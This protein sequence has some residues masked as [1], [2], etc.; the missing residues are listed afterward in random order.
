MFLE[1]TKRD[2][3]FGGKYIIMF[4]KIYT[5]LLLC[6]TFAYKNVPIVYLCW[7]KMII[8]Y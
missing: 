5:L 2:S 7:F 3:F 1:C 6:I 4:L 8:N